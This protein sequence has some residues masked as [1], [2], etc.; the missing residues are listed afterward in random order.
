MSRRTAGP[1]P[2]LRRAVLALAVVP[3]LALAGCSSS[4]EPAATPTPTPT[5]TPTGLS[6]AAWADDVCTALGDLTTNIGAIGDGLSVQLGSGDAL[7]QLT[8]QLGA[9][10]ATAGASLDD[11]TSAIGDAPDTDEATALKES[12]QASAGD[13]TS[14]T[15]DARAAAQ[16]AADATNVAG[17]LGSAG[18]AL[19]ATSTALT[20]AKEYATT[21]LSAA[22][23]SGGALKSAF[24]DAD[25]CTA[26]SKES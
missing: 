13:V 5:P 21:L 3:L 9:N 1:R 11:L 12:L 15:R 22:A 20:A 8:K 6:A 18:T 25:S 2:S 23:G 19:T 10:V 24:A 7:D 4:G 14:A 26:L 16:Q 17:F